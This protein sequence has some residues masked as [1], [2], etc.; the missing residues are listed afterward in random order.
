M[1][2]TQQSH[3]H[4]ARLD[5]HRIGNVY[6]PRFGFGIGRL[7]ASG[8]DDML[9]EIRE[10]VDA[11]GCNSKVIG[12]DNRMLA[13]LCDEGARKVAAVIDSIDGVAFE[14][15][16]LALNTAI[17]A[18]RCG[19]GGAEITLVA[20]EILELVRKSAVATREMRALLHDNVRKAEAGFRLVDE[21][22][23]TMGDIVGAVRQVTEILS[24][25]SRGQ[26]DDDE[27]HPEEP[28]TA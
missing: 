10:A 3:A 12:E 8:L 6:Y 20:S 26:V 21:V 23:A 2:A 16:L 9:D 4:S 1:T 11:I 28:A 19:A 13:R 5:A 25:M 14:T 18:S 24:E 7:G 22:G 17:E 15:N 27:S